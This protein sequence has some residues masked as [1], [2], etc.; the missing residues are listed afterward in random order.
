MFKI[1]IIIA[2]IRGIIEVIRNG[3]NEL[4]VL[5]LILMVALGILIELR[6]RRGLE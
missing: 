6:K 4:V 3:Y 1:I 5:H 2:A